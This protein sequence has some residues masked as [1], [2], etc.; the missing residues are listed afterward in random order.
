VRSVYSQLLKLLY[1]KWP[2]K[3]DIQLPYR[4]LESDGVWKLLPSSGRLDRLE[5]GKALHG[6]AQEILKHVACAELDGEVFREL[7]RSPEARQQ[8]LDLLSRAY[9]PP[10][11][12]D[13]LRNAG[14]LP[15]DL[16]PTVETPVTLTERAL[17]EH[18]WEHWAETPFPSMGVELAT[19]GRQVMTPVNCIDLLGIHK[20]K[21]ESWVF[22]L[23]KGRPADRVVG[24]LQRYMGWIAS[25]RGVPTLGAVIAGESDRK[26]RYA[27]KANPSVKLWIYDQDFRLRPDEG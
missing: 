10:G 1:P 27:V 15:L 6:K 9:F 3:G 17:E 2:F 19:P 21:G 13:L 24:Q 22:E 20:E 7:S 4:H 26:L 16:T 11:A 8:V 18:L 25:D 23:K 14:S 12:M 5:T